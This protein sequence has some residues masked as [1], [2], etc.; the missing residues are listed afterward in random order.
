MQAPLPL[1]FA[2]APDAGSPWLRPISH[3]LGDELASVQRAQGQRAIERRAGV[4]VYPRTGVAWSLAP[5]NNNEREARNMRTYIYLDSVLR[6]LGIMLGAFSREVG[7][8]AGEAAENAPT[9]RVP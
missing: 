3:P 8:E 1:I 5:H 6:V 2:P 7:Q 4:W 9:R